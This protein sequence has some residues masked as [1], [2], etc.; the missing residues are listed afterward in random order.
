MVAPLI[1]IAFA[2]KHYCYWY[3]FVF[4][5]Q[6]TEHFLEYSKIINPFASWS[7]LIFLH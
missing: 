3:G 7:L 4:T 5:Y 2:V 6:Y 1:I